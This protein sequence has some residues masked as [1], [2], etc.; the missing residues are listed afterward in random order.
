M[1]GTMKLCHIGYSQIIIFAGSRLHEFRRSLLLLS[2][3]YCKVSSSGR[4]RSGENSS[5]STYWQFEKDGEP[6]SG[7]T[8]CSVHV[9]VTVYKCQPIYM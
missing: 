1:I 8:F 7:M 2:A 9:Y 4:S 6:C 3:V 5:G